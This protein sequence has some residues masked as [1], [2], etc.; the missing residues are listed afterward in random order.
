MGLQSQTR[1]SNWTT[2]HLLQINTSGINIVHF[3]LPSVLMRIFLDSIFLHILPRYFKIHFSLWLSFTSSIS[4]PSKC[5]TPLDFAGESLR[6][7]FPLC[8]EGSWSR[9]RILFLFCQSLFSPPNSF[10]KRKLSTGATSV[11]LSW[12]YSSDSTTHK[13][14]FIDLQRLNLR[15]VELAPV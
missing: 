12:N 1:L 10:R 11:H 13:W 14:E 4:S 9:K 2:I 8:R 7:R 15:P 5:V 3:Y 6:S